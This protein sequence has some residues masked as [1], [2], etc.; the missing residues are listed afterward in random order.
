MYYLEDKIYIE[1]SY[2]EVMTL[3]NYNWISIHYF[4]VDSWRRVF[5][6][7]NMQRAIEGGFDNLTTT[8][9]NFMYAFRILF[10]G[11]LASKLIYF[12]ANGMAI[13]QHLKI[14]I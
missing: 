13:F 1:L 14:G 12:G 2:D 3:D 9:V 8:L 10:E 7:L 11:Y 4:V 5:I 6:F